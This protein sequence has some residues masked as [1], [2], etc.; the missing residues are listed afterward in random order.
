ML[1]LNRRVGE[2]LHI[3]DTITVT[4]LEDKGGQIRLGINAPKDMAIHRSE[5]YAKLGATRPTSSKDLADNWNRCYPESV[6]VA[7]RSH[8]D[9]GLIRT[10]SLGKA[11]LSA[12]GAAVIWLEGQGTPVLLRNCTPIT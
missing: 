6:E 9:A 11:K 4:V 10:R 7:Y 1:I 8:P 2:T 3:G 5:I 12:S